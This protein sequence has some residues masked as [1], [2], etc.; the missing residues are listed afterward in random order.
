MLRA[1]AHRLSLPAAALLVA[2]CLS[3]TSNALKAAEPG[4]GPVVKFDVFHKPFPEIPLPN[5]FATRFDPSSPTHRRLNASIEAGPNEWEK[6]T[7]ADLDQLTGWG[8]LAPITVAF[9]EPIDPEVI[10]QRHHGD[11]LDFQNDAVLVLDVTPGS[12][13]LCEAVPLDLGQGNYPETLQRL[14]VYSS[15]PRASLQQ[16]HF[17][18]VEEDLNHNGQLDP[19]E[20]TD[21]DGVL[22]HPNTRDGKEGGQLLEF[23]ERETNTLIMKPM[24]PMRE[25]TTY[26]T[27]LTKRLTSKAG[28]PVR[29]P[30]DGINHTAQTKDLGGLADCLTRY[31]L[32]LDDVAFT[33]SFTTQSISDDY[34]KVRDGLYGLG[35]MSHLGTDFPAELSRLRDVRKKTSATTNTKIVPGDDARAMMLALLK[36][37]GASA[38]DQALA[39][40]QLRSIDFQVIG[41]VTSPQFFPKADAAGATLPYYRQ[42]WNLDAAPRPEAVPFWLF[43]PKN[44]HGPAPVAVFIHG[45]GG[46]KF[47][48]LEVAGL[49]ARYGV[50]TLA[51]DGPGHGIGLADV[52]RQLI[53]AQFTN[54]GL[55][56]LGQGLLDGRAVDVNG[57]GVLDPGADYWTSYVFHTRDM[58]RQTMVDLMQV[59]R[60]LKGFDGSAHWS[61]DVNRDGAP[62]L[63]GDFNGDGVVDIGGEAATYVFGG[64]LG[65]ITSGVAAGVEPRLEAALALVPGGMLSEVGGRS[66]LGGVRNA[67]VLR[68]MAP[69]FTTQNG[70][71]TMTVNDAESE[72]KDLAVHALPALT[73]K[74]TVV[75]INTKTGEHRCG[76]VQPGGLFRVAVACDKGDPLEFRAYQG[77][78]APEAR[79]GCALPT[80]VEPLVTVKSLDRD[81]KLG[82]STFAKG[83]ALV[84]VQDGFGLR[85]ATPDLR[86]LFGLSQ[87]ALESA[88]P[89]NWAPYWEKHRELTYG[90]GETVETRMLLVP[91]A[92]DPGVP[93]ASGIALAR[94][95]GFIEYDKVDARYGKSQMQVLIDSWA[96]EGLS[97]TK[98]FT[99]A[100]GQG[101]L[102]DV[103][104]LAAVANADDGFGVP[105]LDPP[106]RLPKYRDGAKGYTGVLIPMLK[107]EGLHGFVTPDPTRAFDLGTFLFN[108]MG[109]WLGSG[110]HDFSLDV[111]QAKSA[112]T[113]TPPNP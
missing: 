89:M 5:D 24:M 29:S 77:T 20:D 70:V 43:V 88:D 101:V 22:D 78:L 26:A 66:A 107:P 69:L 11:L 106:L 105:R 54:K 85:R 68:M 57:D 8:T 4:N 95:A 71:L 27:V 82:G 62:D 38:A 92:G 75:L 65:G 12:P 112:C 94:A 111:C 113:W 63:A 17:E 86:R 35:A 31:G 58:V 16:L 53:L 61:Y 36:L 73:E 67:M 14:D 19:G 80:G 28:D 50:A 44:R 46:S 98:R 56:G 30:F 32:N 99:N 13:G 45:H 40:E 74:D 64:S 2:G 108:V 110:G 34:K 48:G 25:A 79:T 7:R 72:A 84:A 39:D 41:E 47:S 3:P 90:T 9:S 51:I 76:A 96:V 109:Q 21:M 18:E 23:Y 37:T 10:F 60:T 100:Q 6:A 33:W 87:I 103:E 49:L 42:V 83:S 104:H 1:H 97:R 59:V 91:S 15:D 93:V 55:E 102:M 52:D 81:I